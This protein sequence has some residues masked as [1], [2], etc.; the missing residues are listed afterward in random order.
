MS[1]TE[2]Q[3]E[4]RDNQKTQD[5]EAPKDL[6]V[7]AALARTAFSSEQSLMSWIRTALSLFTLGFSI[8]QFFQYLDEKQEIIKLSSG[9]RRLGIALVS[10]GIAALLLALLDHVY[11]IKKMKEEG[12]PPEASSFLPV[13]SALALLVIGIAALVSILL[14][15]TL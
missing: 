14:N 9:P 6:R 15:W 10:V 11:H 8:T 2:N 4:P 7:P 3:Q 1:E 5:T 13:G 12:L